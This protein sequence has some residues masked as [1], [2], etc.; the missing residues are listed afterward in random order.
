MLEPIF[1]LSMGGI[2]QWAAPLYWHIFEYENQTPVRSIHIWVSVMETLKSPPVT[3]E[4]MT[5]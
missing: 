4:E 1:L 2:F 3:I 5:K